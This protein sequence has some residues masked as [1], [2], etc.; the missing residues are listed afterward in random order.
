MNEA[1]QVLAGGQVLTPDGLRSGL[2]VVLA[3][4]RI[5]AVVPAGEAGPATTRLASDAILAPGFIDA[6]VNGGGGVLFNDDPSPAGL[7]AITAA[8]RRFGTTGLLPTLITDA[9]ERMQAAAE[10]VVA[11]MAEP[12]SGVLGVHF[13]GPFISTERPGVHDPRHIRPITAADV[14]FLAGCAARLPGS[15]LLTVAPECVPDE[16]L[17]RLAAAGVILSAGHTAASFERMRAAFGLGVRG[18]THLF[19]AMPQPASRAP[20][21][22]AAAMLDAGS[23]CG[24]IADG[25]HVHPAMLRLALRCKTPGRVYLVTDAMPPTGTDA[26]GFRLGGR[27]I[28]RRDGRLTAEDGTLAGADIDMAAAVRNAVGMLGVEPAEALRMAS[29]CPADFLRL[30]DR[31]RIAPGCQ[32]DLVQLSPDLRV[33]GSWVAGEWQ[34]A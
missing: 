34:A 16:T 9:P 11:A 18:A 24:I 10:A 19:N 27:T 23:W 6:Q 2:A 30:A 4:A 33:E 29:T 22:A 15:V 7:R 32:A 8:H 5:E 25:I 14:D 28:L 3:G 13:E 21:P 31:G 17:E 12:G 26:T 1:R 20:G